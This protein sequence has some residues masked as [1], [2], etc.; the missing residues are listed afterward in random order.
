M[1]F[2]IL[3][4]IYY[5]QIPFSIALS[6]RCR[7]SSDKYGKNKP[8]MVLPRDRFAD[9][10]LLPVLFYAETGGARKLQERHSASAIWPLS[11]PV[12]TWLDSE[13]PEPPAQK[14]WP[15]RNNNITEMEKPPGCYRILLIIIF[16]SAHYG[17]IP[18]LLRYY[19]DGF[20]DIVF[21]GRIEKRFPPIH[22]LYPK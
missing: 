6:T 9:S 2:L 18:F 1:D 13:P 21:Y 11:T 8:E 16:N 4:P 15:R 17:N 7:D 5:C 12:T 3:N 20:K 22:G 14:D 19:R 10:N